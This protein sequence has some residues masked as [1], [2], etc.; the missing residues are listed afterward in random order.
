MITINGVGRAVEGSNFG[1]DYGYNNGGWSQQYHMA[2]NNSSGH[3][4]Y[5]QK[6]IYGY[7]ASLPASITTPFTHT[8]GANDYAYGNY[9]QWNGTGYET[10]SAKL[11]TLTVS[12][13]VGA[14]PEPSTWA[15]MLLGFAGVGFAAYRKRKNGTFSMAAAWS[16]TNVWYSRPLTG[17]GFS[18]SRMCSALAPHSDYGNGSR[19]EGRVG[20]VAFSPNGDAATGDF[21]DANVIRKF[22]D[23]P[24]N[25][26]GLWHPQFIGAENW[27]S[28]G[29]WTRQI[30]MSFNW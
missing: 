9:Y 2:E 3:T 27:V 8:V 10:I 14:V 11:A 23:V 4:E 16:T 17:G 25:L 12:E 7:Y 26:S 19:E 22:G 24:D 13:H 20:A 18:L 1:E 15:M 6:S 29:S 28:A 30:I 21:S 5:L